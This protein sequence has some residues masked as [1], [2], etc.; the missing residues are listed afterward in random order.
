MQ[1]QSL[2]SLTFEK[3]KKE[4]MQSLEVEMREVILSHSRGELFICPFCNYSSKK[5]SKGSAKKFNDSFFCFS[6]HVWRAV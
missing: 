1:T 3:T 5:N 6:C 2:N 4:K